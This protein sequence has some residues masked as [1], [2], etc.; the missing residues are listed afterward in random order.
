MPNLKDFFIDRSTSFTLHEAH[1]GDVIIQQWDRE[2]MGL[3]N[4]EIGEE[5]DVVRTEMT[6][7][8]LEG[9]FKKMEQVV[10]LTEE[11]KEAVRS[12]WNEAVSMD[13]KVQ[14]GEDGSVDIVTED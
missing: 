1:D 4:E 8:S 10:P 11:T 12:M 13:M 2:S 3:L 14:V 9:A 7:H 5:E 6:A